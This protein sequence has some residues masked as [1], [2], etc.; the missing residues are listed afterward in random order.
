MKHVLVT[1]LFFY[2]PFFYTQELAVLSSTDNNPLIYANILFFSNGTQV[3]GCYTDEQGRAWIDTSLSIDTIG[4]IYLGY[5]DTSFAFRKQKLVRLMAKEVK[6]EEVAVYSGD[7]P[8]VIIGD[9][10]KS[11][12]IKYVNTVPGGVELVRLD[13]PYPYAVKIDKV[14]FDYYRLLGKCKP[15][16]RILFYTIAYGKNR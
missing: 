10:K 5:Y 13:N 6:L 15:K 12:S 16:Y 3:G 14:L 8:A 9:K 7:R 11:T 4:I 2:V 1:I